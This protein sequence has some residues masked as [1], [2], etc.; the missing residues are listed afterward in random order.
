M[1]VWSKRM[2]WLDGIGENIDDN[3]TGP[4]TKLPGPVVMF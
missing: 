4:G 3:T 1:A 2:M